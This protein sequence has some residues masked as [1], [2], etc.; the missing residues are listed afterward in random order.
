MATERGRW[1]CGGGVGACAG[2]GTGEWV[3]AGPG[4]GDSIPI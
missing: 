4:T 2:G 1:A 3:T